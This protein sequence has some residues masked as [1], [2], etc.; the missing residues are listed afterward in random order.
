VAR[1]GQAFR[2]SIVTRLFPPESTVI[3]VVSREMGISVATLERW[4]AQ[5]LTAPSELAGS[6]FA[7]C[8]RRGCRR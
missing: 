3:N 8:R 1:Y 4:R 6:Q 2:D 7:G 5:I